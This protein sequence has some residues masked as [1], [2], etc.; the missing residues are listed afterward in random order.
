MK[1]DSYEVMLKMLSIFNIIDRSGIANFQNELELMNECNAFVFNSNIRTR[2][3]KS[4]F[5][6]TDLISIFHHIIDLAF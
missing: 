1:L 2:E 4:F 5:R 3:P 6:R